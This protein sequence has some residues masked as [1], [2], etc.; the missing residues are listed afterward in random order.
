MMSD[1]SPT[2]RSLNP[3]ALT[4]T[5]LLGQWV[6][7]ARSAMA[8]PDSEEG[9][10]MRA[11]VVDIITLQ[12]V[13]FSLRDLDKLE[14]DEQLLGLD[15]AEVL[16]EKHESAIRNRWAENIP[17]KLEEMIQDARNQLNDSSSA[18]PSSDH[19]SPSSSSSNS[20]QSD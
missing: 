14:R 15:R 5:A 18:V 20:S 1:A 8:L 16:I 2:N 3:Q 4:W 6:E 13:W 9:D 12:A 7:F 11:S 10:A 19:S 17:E